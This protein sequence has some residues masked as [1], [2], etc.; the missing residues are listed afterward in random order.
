MRLLFYLVN[1][2]QPQETHTLYFSFILSAIILF[3][4]KLQTFHMNAGKL[5][6]W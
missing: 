3:V 6:N 5:A 4:I 2:T 1:Y